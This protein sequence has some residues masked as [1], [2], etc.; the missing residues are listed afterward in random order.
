MIVHTGLVAWASWRYSP[1]QDECGHLAAGLGLWKFQDFS[2]YR[3]NPPLVR[4]V[5]AA[6]LLLI[7][8]KEDWTRYQPGAT[9]RQEFDLGRRFF[10]ANGTQ[11]LWMLSVSRW[12]CLPFTLIGLLVCWQ[13]G[14][15][16]AGDHAGIVAAGFWCFSPNIIGHGALITSDIAGVSLGLLAAWRFSRWLESPNWPLAFQAGI[17]LGLALLSKLS[18]VVLFPIWPILWIASRLPSQRPHDIKKEAVQFVLIIGLGINILNLGYLFDG[19][20]TPLGELEFFSTP[21]AGKKLLPGGKP[22]S[23]PFSGH[24][25]QTHSLALPERISPRTR[26]AEE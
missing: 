10:I 3:V 26:F 14:R 24:N 23:E 8:H 15:E 6:P 2:L 22:S 1:T 25:F 7:D 13:W 16:I 19:T 17:A 11:S 5:A 4:T 21:L 12:C 9:V 18:W 20:G